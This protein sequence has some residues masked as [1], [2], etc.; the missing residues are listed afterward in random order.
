MKEQ[1][2]SK[3]RSIPI[4]RPDIPDWA[5]EDFLSSEHSVK[6]FE[7]AFS[8]YMGGSGQAALTASG[9]MAIY[10]LFKLLGL[11]GNVITSPLSCSMAYAPIIANGMK[12]KFVDINP[13]TFVL[14]ESKA[15]GCIDV[16]TAAIYVVHLGGTTP[17]MA[18]LRQIAD[19][20]NVL[21]IEDCAQGLGSQFSGR[22]AGSFGHYSCFSFAKNM[23][24][25]GCGA[26]FSHNPVLI[27]KIREHQASLPEAPQGLLKYR[28]ERDM[29]ESRRGF[30]DVAD[31]KYYTDFVMPAKNANV[32]I[33]YN[34]Y[35]TKKDVY[36][37]PSD[38]QA[39]LLY[40]QLL[41]I[42]EKNYVRRM[43][44]HKIINGLDDLGVFQSEHERQ[45]VY[46]KLYFVPRRD[47]DNRTT[48]PMLVADGIDAKHLTKSHGVH[49]QERFDMWDR[50][51]PFVAA[52]SLEEYCRIHDKIVALPISSKMKNEEVSHIINRC[53]CIFG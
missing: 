2:F 31:Q 46:S 53:R 27:Q 42:D 47:L 8:V 24:L 34:G 20:H 37:R 17:D 10:L 25:A 18:R 6:D 38:I 4:N 1:G 45:S 33:D 43:T 51:R 36:C 5:F 12:L 30:D 14:D 11:K 7:S 48:I 9:K 21:L 52:D 49:F 13:K 16:N 15:E 41:T 39:S 26:V 22:K 40:E 35:F 32:G 29:L 23:W 3:V 28:F 50:F 19:E 44:A